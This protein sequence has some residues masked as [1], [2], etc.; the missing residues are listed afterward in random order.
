LYSLWCGDVKPRVA[1]GPVFRWGG[2]TGGRHEFH[3]KPPSHGAAKPQPNGPKTFNARFAQGAKGIRRYRKNQHLSI[4]TSIPKQCS[5]SL[6][7]QSGSGS[8]P[9]ALCVN[10]FCSRSLEE[11]FKVARADFYLVIPCSS[12][13]LIGAGSG[14][15]VGREADT[16]FTPSRQATA[17]QS[18]NRT[19]QRHLTPASLK[20]QRSKGAT[21]NLTGESRGHGEKDGQTV[22]RW[23]KPQ[24]NGP[25]KFNARFA[26]GAARQSRHRNF[27]RR[28]QRERRAEKFCQKCTTLRHS[29]AEARVRYAPAGSTEVRGSVVSDNPIRKT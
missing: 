1:D 8:A 29:T 10:P 21:E 2:G 4:G 13:F 15:S 14:V 23:A 25:R 7:S 19:A 16:N 3:A 5:G 27:H 20:A 24:P 9:L 18:R 17:C 12:L 28:T 22:G 11:G 6:K 26:Q